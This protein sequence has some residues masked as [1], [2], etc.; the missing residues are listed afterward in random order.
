VSG[1]Q[2]APASLYPRERLGTHF[3]RGWVGPR[4]GLDG[5]KISSPWGSIPG[6]PA[7][8]SVAIPTELPGP[9]V[10]F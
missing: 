4:G 1:Q 3:T 8:S 7:F 10:E 9:L 5:W 2:H 6:R